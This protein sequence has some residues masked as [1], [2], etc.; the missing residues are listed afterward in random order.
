MRTDDPTAITKL[1][2]IRTRPL[3]AVDLPII[4]RFPRDPNRL[5]F[6]KVQKTGPPG[7]KFLVD[8]AGVFGY[9]LVVDRAVS[10]VWESATMALWRSPVR[11][12]YGPPKK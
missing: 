6:H 2:L 9:I 4:L 8:F 7:N 1:S 11:P 3:A 10:S 5:L 12:R